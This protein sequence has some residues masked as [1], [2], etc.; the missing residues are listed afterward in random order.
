MS[1]LLLLATVCN[2]CSNFV[3]RNNNI[4][5]AELD[6]KIDAQQ[7]SATVK[8][9]PNLPPNVWVSWRY[10]SCHL[11]VRAR[12]WFFFFPAFVFISQ[13]LHCL[14]VVCWCSSVGGVWF[15]KKYDKFI[16]SSSFIRV[17]V[18][19]VVRVLFAPPTT[20]NGQ[21]KKRRTNS[22]FFVFLSLPSRWKIIHSFYILVFGLFCARVMANCV[23]FLLSSTFN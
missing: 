21:K 11:C 5:A 1:M 3:F 22:S 15:K 9:N 4:C 6:G 19:H 14:T 13:L 18:Q 10:R 2:Q 17:Y 23:C 20:K 16:R 7:P 12:S 8:T